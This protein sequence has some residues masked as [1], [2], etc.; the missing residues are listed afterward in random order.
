[1]DLLKSSRSVAEKLIAID[2][3]FNDAYLAI[4]IENYV[5]GLRSAPT[6]WVLR[7]SGAETDRN[8][9]IADLKI[10]AEKGRYLAPYAQILLTIA[11]FRDHDVAAARS[12]LSELVREFPQNQLYRTELARLQG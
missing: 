10:T 2:P 3:E 12:L 6:R 5:L 8:K 11:A 1:L 4:G 7:L 9:G